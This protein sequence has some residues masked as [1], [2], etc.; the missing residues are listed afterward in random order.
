MEARLRTKDG[1]YRWFSG[2]AKLIGVGHN[3]SPRLIVGLSDVHDLVTERVRASRNERRLASVLETLLDPHLTLD[4][5]RDETGDIT[6]FVCVEANTAASRYLGIAAHQLSGMTLGEVLCGQAGADLFDNCVDVIRTGEPL[7]LDDHPSVDRK[8]QSDRR[9]LDIRVSRVDDSLNFT[10]RDVTERHRAQLLLAESQ[11]KYQRLAENAADIVYEVSLEGRLLWVSPSVS[12]SLGWEPDQLL[13]QHVTRFVHSEDLAT[14]GRSGSVEVN[15]EARLRTANGHWRWMRISGRVL[16]DAAGQATG[17]IET[18]HDIQAEMDARARLAHQAGHDPLTGLPNRHTLLEHLQSAIDTSSLRT[19]YLITVGVD[20]LGALIDAFTHTA[21]DRVISHIAEQLTS[22]AGITL[23]A[24][25][26]DDEF[27]VV[28]PASELDAIADLADA[29]QTAVRA[30]VQIGGH[31][32][33]V[34]VSL[35]IAGRSAATT[36]ETWLQESSTAL[37]HA[38]SLGG[39]RWEFHDEHM[40]RTARERV[41]VRSAIREGLG[42]GRFRAWFQPV[43]ALGNRAVVGHEALC[44]WITADGTVVGPDTFIPAAD[45]ANLI[46]D[47]DRTM[48]RQALQ[49]ASQEP[50]SQWVSV[51]M[52]AASLT[53]ASLVEAVHE[54][55]HESGT[56]PAR[57]Q[58]EVTEN[59]LMRDTDAARKNMHSLAEMGVC[60]WVDDFGTGYSSIAHLRDLPVAGLKLDRSFTKGITANATRAR[61]AQGLIGL[62]A[63]LGLQTVA[64]GIETEPEA[65]LLNLQGWQMG[66]G[67]LF[68]RPQP[69]G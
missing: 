12:Q 47:L 49:M 18:A 29:I 54:I 59:S 1:G 62:A 37:H 56:D 10:F 32:I 22:L 66:Q 2:R 26:S 38:K 5:I 21:S 64:E 58:L 31:D 68:G 17:F 67:W 33:D 55:L 60:W 40:A 20:D 50:R 15:R 51:N 19:A 36:A 69:M 39:N 27:A 48:L 14:R 24:R 16:R 3:G 30:P 7:V 6:D 4:A 34:T 9:F 43:V 42:S 8:R 63:G 13:G 11:S 52:S 44:R 65:M 41:V 28:A 45:H 57:L 35:G 25:L 53:E 46:V 61:L 23:T